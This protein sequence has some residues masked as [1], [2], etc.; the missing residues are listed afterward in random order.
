M[1][2]FTTSGGT[3]TLPET[4]RGRVR[5]L[6]YKTI[7]YPGHGKVFRALADLG[8]LSR[9]PVEVNGAPI[10]PRALFAQVA[11]PVLDRGVP[12]VVLLRLTAIGRRAGKTVRRV[13]QMIEY[14]DPEHGLTA[15][16]RTTAFPAT[17]VLLM[18]AR[19]EITA[20]GA[21]P[22]ERCVDPP[23]FLSELRARGIE[24]AVR[25]E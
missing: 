14:P 1:E 7:R 24:V 6:T 20:K 2:A 12:D 22:Q 13:Y 8:L 16:M 17:I 10:S 15:M 4:Y 25:E 23:R 21:L 3:S 18:L 9:D 19:G 5:R 11:T